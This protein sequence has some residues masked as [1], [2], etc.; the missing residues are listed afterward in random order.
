MP[1]PLRCRGIRGATT[2]DED[3]ESGILESTRELLSQLL[4]ANQLDRNEITAI[5]FTCTRD[6]SATFPARAARELGLVHLP[7]LCGQ[8]MN[9][10]G[11][12]ERCIRI[13]LLVNTGRTPEQLRHVYLRGAA[14]LRPDFAFSQND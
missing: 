2:A 14:N 12:P 6:L 7:L 10:P 3:S 5:F 1:N 4:S 13:L 9:V 8:E 11:A